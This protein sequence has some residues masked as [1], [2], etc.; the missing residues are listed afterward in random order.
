MI[1]LRRLSV[2]ITLW[3]VTF[4]GAQ[5]MQS[6][7]YPTGLPVGHATGPSIAL[8]GSGTG[9]QNDFFGMADNT[10]NLGGI[11]RA[12]FG[13]LVSFDLTSI[14]QENRNDVRGSFSPRLF[15]FAVP[16]G[17]LGTIGFSIDQRSVLNTKFRKPGSLSFSTGETDTVDLG[18]VERG[19]LT[20]WQAGWGRSIGRHVRAGVGYERLY[21]SRNEITQMYSNFSSSS[22]GSIASSQEDTVAI[23]FRGNTVRAGVLASLKKLTV[24]CSGEY[25]FHGDARSREDGPHVKDTSGTTFAFHLPPTVSAGASYAFTPGWLAAMECDITLWKSNYYSGITLSRPVHN[26]STISL[27]GQFIPAPN[28]LMPR[29]WEIMQYRAGFR[30]SQLPAG[31]ASEM[32]FTLS[33]GLPIQ[34]GGGLFDLIFEFGRRSD[35]NYKNNSEQFLRIMLGINGGRKWFQSTETRY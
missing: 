11:S 13:A 34:Q 15:S 27:G 20:A 5:S 2:I 32:A 22:E 23:A 29:Y 6:Y 28:L 3:C 8:A 24:G 25:I 21:F 7:Q 1:D 35:S 4:A 33:L 26:A 31:T 30:F 19:A 9:V 12:V 14:I 10:A 17:W 16:F 18:I